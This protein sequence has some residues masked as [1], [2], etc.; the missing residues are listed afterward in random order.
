[1]LKIKWTSRYDSLG[2]KVTSISL[3]TTRT[4]PHNIFYPAPPKRGIPEMSLFLKI[5][6]TLRFRHVAMEEVFCTSMQSE[7][8]LNT[9][10]C[11]TPIPGVWGWLDFSLCPGWREGSGLVGPPGSRALVK[12]TTIESLFIRHSHYPQYSRLYRYINISHS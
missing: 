11:S 1:M 4:T 6:Q 12:N 2:K 9:L 3:Y 10:W 7:T 5:D 8:F